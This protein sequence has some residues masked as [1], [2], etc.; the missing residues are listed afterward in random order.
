MAL[1]NQEACRSNHAC[2]DTEHIL[3]GLVKEGTGMAAV[4]LR[5]LEIDRGPLQACLEAAHS[6]EPETKRLPQSSQARK[7]IECA[8]E[9]ARDLDHHYCGTEH[10]LLG[11]LRVEDGNAARILQSQGID[12]ASARRV[13]RNLRWP[14]DD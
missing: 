4:V 7:V 14:K 3:W 9:E 10:L 13:V 8:I 11:L 1:A 6:Q 2:I 5:K 12:F